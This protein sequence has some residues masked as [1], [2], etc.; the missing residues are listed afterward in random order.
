MEMIAMAQQ[1]DFEAAES[2]DQTIGTAKDAARDVAD[3][4]RDVAKTRAQGLFESGKIAAAARL[5]DVAEALR[6]ASDRSQAQLGISHYARRAADRV[7][8][9][10][11]T[12]R[13]RDLDQMIEA[14]ESFARRDTPAFL[15]GSFVAGLALARFLKASGHRRSTQSSRSYPQ[16]P[17]APEPQS[18]AE[19]YGPM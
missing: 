11:R 3:A 4:A 17:D 19:P 14:A 15:A 1:R 16:G 7:E 6:A 9:A 13:E 10:S 12:L 2:V 18:T 5:D 8:S